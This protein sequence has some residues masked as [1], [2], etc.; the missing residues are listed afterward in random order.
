MSNIKVKLDAKRLQAG[1]GWTSSHNLVVKA[2][3]PGKAFRKL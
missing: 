2:S 1:P 3:Q